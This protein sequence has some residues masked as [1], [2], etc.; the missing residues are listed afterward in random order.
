MLFFITFYYIFICIHFCSFFYFKVPSIV[1]LVKLLWSLFL[2]TLSYHKEQ[3]HFN[4]K[5]FFK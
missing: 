4:S 2:N 5:I 3:E 1:D